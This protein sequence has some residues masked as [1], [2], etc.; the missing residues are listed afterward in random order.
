MHI[1][2]SGSSQAS[3]DGFW[4]PVEGVY[5]RDRPQ[6]ADEEDSETNEEKIRVA[7]HSMRHELMELR[8]EA[9]RSGRQ[10]GAMNNI[11]KKYAEGGEKN[12]TQIEVRHTDA[13]GVSEEEEDKWRE[14]FGYTTRRRHKSDQLQGSD[15]TQ[16]LAE[17]LHDEVPLGRIET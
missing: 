3:S 10:A 11:R 4:V 7:K 5:R 2:T 15:Q 13:W 9:M 17:K 6:F 14:R 8:L 1:A 16:S 12:A